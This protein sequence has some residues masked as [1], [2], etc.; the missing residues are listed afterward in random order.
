MVLTR[1]RQDR[2]VQRSNIMMEAK[3]GGDA[4]QPHSLPGRCGVSL[5][6]PGLPPAAAMA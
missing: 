2:Q 4:G 3:F 6:A 5:P 1:E